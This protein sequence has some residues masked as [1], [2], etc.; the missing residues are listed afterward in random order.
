MAKRPLVEVEPTGEPAAIV[1][2]VEDALAGEAPAV[3]TARPSHGH[4]TV[5]YTGGAD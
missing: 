1:E 5:A 2:A 3:A 4:P